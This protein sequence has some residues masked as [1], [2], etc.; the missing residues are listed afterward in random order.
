VK[1]LVWSESPYTNATFAELTAF[2]TVGM[3]DVASV[4]SGLMN[5]KWL[6]T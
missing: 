5:Y 4:D 6:R 2:V 3:H 1:E